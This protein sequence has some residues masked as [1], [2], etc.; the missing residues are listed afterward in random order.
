MDEKRDLAGNVAE[1]LER[2]DIGYDL[3][4]SVNLNQLVEN[5]VISKEE[6]ESFEVSI[7]DIIIETD[8]LPVGVMI[9]I[10]RKLYRGVKKIGP[11]TA[12]Q[13]VQKIS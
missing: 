6:L 1:I 12:K 10:Q 8:Q 2:Y 3:D 11:V 9:S 4:F 5:G 7:Y 13:K